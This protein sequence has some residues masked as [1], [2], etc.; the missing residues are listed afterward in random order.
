MRMRLCHEICFYSFVCV[1][2][3]VNLA[4]SSPAGGGR[5]ER[6]WSPASG[7]NYQSPDLSRAVRRVL[8]AAFELLA[9]LDINQYKW[10]S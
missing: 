9:V 3:L 7:C 10:E 4:K 2:N 5:Q 8:A 6:A 1:T